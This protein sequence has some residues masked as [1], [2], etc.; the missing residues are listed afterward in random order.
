MKVEI[1]LF[2][3][4]SRHPETKKGAFPDFHFTTLSL[5]EKTCP[6]CGQLL[7]NAECSCEKYNKAK[8]ALLNTFKVDEPLW[9]RQNID[10][11]PQSFLNPSDVIITP[12]APPDNALI[13][14]D[15]GTTAE[16]LAAVKPELW[17]VSRGE[18][19]TK[20]LTFYIRKRGDV[21]YYFC[22]IKNIPPNTLCL[23]K[24]ATKIILGYT[25]EETIVDPNAPKGTLGNYHIEPHEH[26][27]A[28]YSYNDYLL[29][30][31]EL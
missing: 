4:L 3:E 17:Y 5:Y 14:F 26:I 15:E 21:Q 9:L 31:T 7:N 19:T 30:L 28:Q 6:F 20:N 1:K 18:L 25:E 27:V 13:L 10:S 12:V 22:E 23:L 11:L 8:K 16:L 24:N 2:S 29:K